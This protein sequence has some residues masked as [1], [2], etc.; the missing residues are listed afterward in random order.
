MEHVF[1]RDDSEREH[2]AHLKLTSTNAVSEYRR[3]VE[4][5]TGG[6]PSFA[7]RGQRGRPRRATT[8]A[9]SA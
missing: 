5:L 9:Q 2:F 7:M 6:L 1:E 4:K 8:K 3:L